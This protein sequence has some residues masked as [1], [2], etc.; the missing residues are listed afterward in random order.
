M[1]GNRWASIA[2]IAILEYS[3]PAYTK[4]ATGSEGKGPLTSLVGYIFQPLVGISRTL[5]SELWR[6]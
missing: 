5:S 4:Y 1:V 2:M 6:M 3:T